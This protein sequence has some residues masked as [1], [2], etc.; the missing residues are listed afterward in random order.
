[1]KKRRNYNHS[2]S[3]CIEHPKIYHLL[4]RREK[5]RWLNTWWSLVRQHAVINKLLLVELRL[6]PSATVWSVESSPFRSDSNLKRWRTVVM[7]QT[8][9]RHHSIWCL[10]AKFRTI[11]LSLNWLIAQC[12]ASN[13]LS[14]SMWRTKMRKRAVSD[15]ERAQWIS[16]SIFFG[17]NEAI[18]TRTKSE[19]L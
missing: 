7:C 14:C 5:K 9:V 8:S 15:V 4:K 19:T 10:F 17:L 18:C 13:Y 2:V 12:T 11:S 16:I 6:H 1:M 3:G